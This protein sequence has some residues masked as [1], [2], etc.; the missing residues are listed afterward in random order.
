MI[1]HQTVLIM[2]FGE[3]GTLNPDILPFGIHT[4]SHTGTIVTSMVSHQEEMT[5]VAA[6]ICCSPL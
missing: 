4:D 5:S 2:F 6:K 3:M 1:C